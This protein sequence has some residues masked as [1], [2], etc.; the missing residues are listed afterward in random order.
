MHGSN[1]ASLQDLSIKKGLGRMI[2]IS[3]QVLQNME[4]IS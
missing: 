2:M 3:F 1:V 4:A